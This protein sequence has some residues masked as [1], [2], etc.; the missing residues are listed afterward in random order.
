MKK[1]GKFSLKLLKY[2]TVNLTS[3]IFTVIFGVLFPIG[4]TALI[5]FAI[6]NNVI[7]DPAYIPMFHTQVFIQMSM[8]IP[9]ATMLMGHGVNYAH[10]LETGAIQR[11]KL[12][13]F[14]EHSIL[15]SKIL[16]HLIFLAISF[17]IYCAFAFIALDIIVPSIWALITFTLFFFIFSAILFTLGHGIASLSGKY[18]R[19]Y[20]I[21]MAVYFGVM[22]LGGMMG[23]PPNQFPN[24]VRHI[25]MGIPLYYIIS[26]QFI[27]F[28]MGI[29]GYNMAGLSVST[30][31][32]AVLAIGLIALSVFLTKKGKISQAAKP[33]YYE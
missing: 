1:Q 8:L 14:K 19:A 2:E 13:G 11:F 27:N 5:A 9:L 24:G 12:Y 26:E 33:V 31:G 18:S 10:E 28:W 21:I 23:V 15:G 20:A 30:A 29:G 22:V 17:A 4:L 32:L 25:A 3:N 6:G 16:S 7:E